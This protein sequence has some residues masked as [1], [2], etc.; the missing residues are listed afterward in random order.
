MGVVTFAGRSS[1]DYG[2]FVEH[3]VSHVIPSR[4]Y[5][6]VHIPGRNGDLHIDRG[7]FNN[8]SREYE[9]VSGTHETN[10]EFIS[11]QV[12]EWL[13]YEKGYQRLEDSY[14]PDYYRMA[15]LVDEV[16]LEN[17]LYHAG[18]GTVKFDCKP[19]RFLIKG[20]KPVTFTENGY[21]VNPTRFD[22]A[23]II[24]VYGEGTVGIGEMTITVLTHPSGIPY[25]DI[26]SD[27][28]DSYYEATNCNSYIS[29]SGTDYPLLHPG[30]NGITIGTGITKAD[31][32]PRWWTV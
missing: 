32:T 27:I 16:E 29:F 20:E 4:D 23:P 6:N 9:I 18:R 30:R 26:D 19:Q 25:I 7:S 2:I 12:A 15:M 1:A 22:A 5:E 17:V 13:H 31:I 28:M 24:R 8:V 14:E 21:I 11:S 3:P 10:Y